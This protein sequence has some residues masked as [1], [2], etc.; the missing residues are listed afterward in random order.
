MKIGIIGLCEAGN[1]GD[2]LILAA[3]LS[4]LSELCPGADVRFLSHGYP[5]D[6]ALSELKVCESLD[7]GRIQYR[8]GILY[9]HHTWFEDRDV[10]IF[11]GG[12]LI[13]DSHHPLRPYQWLRLLP[14]NPR[15]KTVA[16]GLGTGP[17]SPHWQKILKQLGDPFDIAFLRDVNSVKLATSWGWNVELS[18]DAVS[19]D[20]IQSLTSPRQYPLDRSDTLGV[21]VR[22]WPGLSAARIAAR[23]ETIAKSHNVS[24]VRIFTLESKG[25]VGV[26][27]DFAN[28]ISKQLSMQND[29]MIYNSD[30][31]TDFIQKMG[32]CSIALSM[33]YHS[34]IIWASLNVPI[35][36]ITYAPKTSALF[37]HEF[38]GLEI[39]SGPARL[40]VEIPETGVSTAAALERALS[41][42]EDGETKSSK[43]RQ[44]ISSIPLRYSFSSV[45]L[46]FSAFQKAKTTARRLQRRN[47]N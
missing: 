6:S 44:R 42:S 31:L 26:D 41:L 19:R 47:I 36:G 25:S 2:D 23:I 24:H 35:Y 20:F 29:I 18:R 46:V 43:A 11:G 40:D 27:V 14:R 30:N 32:D 28:A 37:G 1:L 12:G 45:A 5:I 22:S 10:V 15:T 9:D 3:L 33:K 34:S 8:E 16:I 38:Q 17:V 4:S 39:L 21:A 13:Q 7:L